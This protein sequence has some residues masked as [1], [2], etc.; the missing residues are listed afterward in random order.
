[1]RKIPP[2]YNQSLLLVA[3]VLLQ[4]KSTQEILIIENFSFLTL[5]I[6]SERSV[7]LQREE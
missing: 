2:L 1:M 4:C 7:P 6:R 5:M 3:D